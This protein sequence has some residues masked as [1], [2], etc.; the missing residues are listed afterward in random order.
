MFFQASG[1]GGMIDDDTNLERRFKK[2]LKNLRVN[3]ALT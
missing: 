3:L 1:D 2:T